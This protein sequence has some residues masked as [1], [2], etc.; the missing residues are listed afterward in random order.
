MYKPLRLSIAIGL[1]AAIP[2]IAQ[3]VPVPPT[4]PQP[5]SPDTPTQPPQAPVPPHPS[6]LLPPVPPAPPAR[7][8]VWGEGL[9]PHS[10]L[11]VMLDDVNDDNREKLKLSES[12]GAVIV[13]VTDDSPAEKAGLKDGDVIIGWNTTRV[14]SAN[15]LSRLVRE[16]PVGR[17]V[18]LDVMRDGHR[19]LIEAKLGVR[20]F[21]LP[22]NFGFNFD[23]L[24]GQLQLLGKSLDSLGNSLGDGVARWDLD[25][26]GIASGEFPLFVA[27]RGRIG[28]ELQSMTP[29]LAKYFGATNGVLIGSVADSG[30][31]RSAGLQ[32]GD[33][34]VSIDGKNVSSPVDVSKIIGEK[35]QGEIEVRIVRDRREQVVRVTVPK[36][37]TGQGLFFD[38]ERSVRFFNDGDQRAIE[39]E[40]Q[41][42]RD[43]GEP[44][45]D[46]VIDLDDL[47]GLDD[48]EDEH[49]FDELPEDK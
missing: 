38:G 27:Q 12:A 22:P 32:A 35:D 14:E 19:M 47:R 20:K 37:E 2:A 3:N 31:A 25:D 40:V 17:V 15:Q 29:Q 46:I 8:R 11:G 34:I 10:Y 39:I 33:V 5:A 18:E 45:S 44:D 6:H 41:R 26:V 21:D 13:E 42:R 4:P 48:L 1:L 30:A 23:S 16:T 43:L 24:N 7:A 9:K 49:E 28:V 36:K